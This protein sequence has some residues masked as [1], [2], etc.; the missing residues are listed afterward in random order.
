MKTISKVTSLILA[1]ALAATSFAGCKRQEP[2]LPD[3]VY[4]DSEFKELASEAGAEYFEAFRNR[5]ITTMATLSEESSRSAFVESAEAYYDYVKSSIWIEE[6]YNAYLYD[7]Q[8][9]E[10]N[11]TRVDDETATIAYKIIIANYNSNQTGALVSYDVKLSFV[12]DAKNESVYVTNPELAIQLYE[13]MVDDYA[14]YLLDMNYAALA[15]T[16]PETTPEPTP[17]PTATPTPVP[18]PPTA[19]PVPVE[20]QAEE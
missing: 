18:P 12:G 14:R 2:E 16:T 1:A 5:N 20:T 3:P 13:D 9:V 6:F 11:F 17:E 4:E 8:I 15:E 19:T 10:S 7:I